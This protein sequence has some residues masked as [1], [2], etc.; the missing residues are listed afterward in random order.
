MIN[1]W[2]IHA[3][4]NPTAVLRL[5]C[6]P[7][8]GAGAS[9]FRLWST[10]APETLEVCCIQPPGREGRLKEPCFTRLEPLVDALVP[11]LAPYLD[12]PFAFF[13]H[14][15]G[16]LISFEVARQLRRD[17]TSNS[18]TYRPVHL[19]LSGRQAPQLPP[20]DAPIHQLPEPEFLEQLRRYNGTPEVVLQSAEL[21][22]L[23][24]PILRADLAINET[25]TYT[26]EPPLDCPISVFAGS[27][28]HLVNSD[29]LNAWQ[30]QTDRAFR[31]QMFPGD[32]FYLKH[33]HKALLQAIAEDLTL[34]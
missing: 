31:V 4:P 30:K 22:S 2:I 3:K 8:A 23:F 18:S 28:D 1:P 15:V 6:F 26:A 16:A 9:V 5:F 7:Y 29:A 10:Q 13:G 25:Y 20:L 21:M 27:Q 11:T 19:F 33:Q 32:H 17:A 14:S 34:N 24:L 12:R